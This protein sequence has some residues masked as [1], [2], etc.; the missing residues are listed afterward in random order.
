MKACFHIAERSLFYSKTLPV[1]AMKA[2]FHIAERSLF[3]SKTLPVSAMKAC[4]HI[5]ERSLFYS[6]TYGIR[7]FKSSYCAYR[8][9]LA[10]ENNAVLYVGNPKWRRKILRLTSKYVQ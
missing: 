3:Y 9:C 4:F 10:N 8:Y 5:A 7:M 2:C 6:K 1:S